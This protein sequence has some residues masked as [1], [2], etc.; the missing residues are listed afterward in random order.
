MSATPRDGD[1]IAPGGNVD[2]AALL[3]LWEQHEGDDET[4][5][6][7]SFTLTRGRNVNKRLDRYLVDR[8]PFLS[9]TSLQRLIREEA[10][11]VNGKVGKPATRIRGG[12]EIEA[13]LP[14][15]PSSQIEAEDIPLD[16]L[17]EDDELIVINKADD[18]IVHPARGNRTGTLIN[19]LAYH[20]QHRSGGGLSRVGEAF[21]RPGVVHRLDRHTTGALVF[22]KSE[23]AHWRLARQ[24]EQRRPEKRYL[25]IGHGEGEPLADVI[26]TP[27][28][29]HQRVRDRYA[30]RWDESAK[31]TA[32]KPWP[33]A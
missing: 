26:D 13:V 5:I 31:P 27:L 17:H 25:A 24:F 18:I 21:A 23:T 29:K 2:R 4:P 3:A 19:G 7:V 33:S 6:S 22:A 9:R 30:V 20:F 1:L 8:I 12:D 14:P 11:T 28:G 15:P 16:V 10:V 32:P